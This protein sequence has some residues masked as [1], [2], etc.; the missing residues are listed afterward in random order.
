MIG[1]D[2]AWDKI[3]CLFGG[4]GIP[5][6]CS[7]SVIFGRTAAKRNIVRSEPFGIGLL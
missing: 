6:Q 4:F 7:M 2:T 5:I 1:I 3:S